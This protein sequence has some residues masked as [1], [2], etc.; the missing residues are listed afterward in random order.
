MSQHIVFYEVKM[1]HA[2]GT[3]LFTMRQRLRAQGPFRLIFMTK[4]IIF[5]TLC[6]QKCNFPKKHITFTYI[7]ST[8]YAQTRGKMKVFSEKTLFSEGKSMLFHAP[9]PPR[10]V[11][12]VWRGNGK[13]KW[14]NSCFIPATFS[15]AVPNTR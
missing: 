2:S 15:F 10:H 1:K 5:L 3:S 13:R 4:S 12:L 7:T 9:D 14:T 11:N 6:T 8:W